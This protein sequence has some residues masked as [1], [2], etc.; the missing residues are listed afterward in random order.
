MIRSFAMT[1]RIILDSLE[2]ECVIGIFDWEREN[3]QKVLIDLTLDCDM[4]LPAKTDDIKD[5]VDYK[6]ISKEIIALLEPSRFYLI[7]KMAEEVAKLCLSHKGVERMTVKI[8]KPEAIRGS[9]N[10]SVEITRPKDGTLIFLGVGGNI[11]PERNLQD[12]MKLICERFAV[13]AVSPTY[14]S[15]AWGVKESQPDY[16]NLA[17]KAVTD[18]DLFAT[19]AE[20]RWIEELL[21]RKRTLDKFSPRTIDI[22]LLMYGDLVSEDEAGTLP[23]PQILTQQFVYAPMMDIAHDV[24]VPGEGRALCDISPAYNDISLELEKVNL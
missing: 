21:G 11:D 3:E 13:L 9:K 6:A 18:K 23:H 16:L 17:V 7:E 22:D 20:I 24:I 19:R 8:S 15:P 1:D 12:G 14:K 4:T 10:V 5:A 2:V